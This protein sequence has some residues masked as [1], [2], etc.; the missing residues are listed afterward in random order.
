MY[1]CVCLLVLPAGGLPAFEP[2]DAVALFVDRRLGEADGLKQK[3]AMNE[4]PL[5]VEVY[6]AQEVLEA[7]VVDVTSEEAGVAGGAGK[8]AEAPME[9]DSSEAACSGS[10]A[11][12]ACIVVV[13]CAAGGS[14]VPLSL[15]GT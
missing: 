1:A 14:T 4:Q 3:P 5:A 6:E 13:T 2:V 11:D 10:P 7:A 8:F 9:M 15:A 12:F